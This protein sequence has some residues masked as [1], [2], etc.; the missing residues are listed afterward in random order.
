MLEWSEFLQ[1]VDPDV[2]I[3]YNISGFDLPYLM[4]R[5][6]HL[7]IVDFPYLGRLNS[8]HAFDPSS[9]CAYAY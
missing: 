9:L 2:I 3:G 4:D 5:A 8:T 7:K 6:K 1:R